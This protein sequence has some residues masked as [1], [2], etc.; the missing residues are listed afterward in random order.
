MN[1]RKILK[2]VCVLGIGAAIG[3]LKGVA[4]CAYHVHK[5][6]VPEEKL[7]EFCAAVDEAKDAL[8]RATNSAEEA[9]EDVAE[10]VTE[11]VEDTVE[12]VEETVEDVIEQITEDQPED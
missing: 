5:G 4:D 3:Y 11:A 9:V 2:G 8:G 6:N 7:D 12:A 1:M 10:E